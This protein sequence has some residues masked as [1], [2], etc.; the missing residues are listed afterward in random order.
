LQ[1]LWLDVSE[2]L[3]LPLVIGQ[4]IIVVLVM[5]WLFRSVSGQFLHFA[6]VNNKQL[7]AFQIQSA[8]KLFGATNAA[9]QKK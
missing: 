8:E 4:F 6:S 9:L 3:G 2:K 5:G 7:K 1:A